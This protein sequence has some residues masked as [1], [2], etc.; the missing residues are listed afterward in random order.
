MPGGQKQRGHFRRE[1]FIDFE[2]TAERHAY[3]ALRLGWTA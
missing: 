1:V 3:E 2:S